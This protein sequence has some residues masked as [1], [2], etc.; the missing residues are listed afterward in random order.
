MTLFLYRFLMHILVNL[1]PMRVL[2]HQCHHTVKRD[3][4]T[5]S[6]QSLIDILYQLQSLLCIQCKPIFSVIIRIVRTIRRR[7]MLIQIRRNM[8]MLVVLGCF[9]IRFF[10][11]IKRKDFATKPQRDILA[12]INECVLPPS[13]TLQSHHR[14]RPSQ[15][16]CC[17]HIHAQYQEQLTNFSQ[18]NERLSGCVNGVIELSTFHHRRKPTV[19]GTDPA[20]VPISH[21]ISPNKNLQFF[22]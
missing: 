7:I 2:L 13:D 10:Q 11:Y 19:C 21:E 4:L 14:S 8:F 15:S 16:A 3:I 12:L 6:I 1:K 17:Q 5:L 18:G 9:F 22:G 20:V